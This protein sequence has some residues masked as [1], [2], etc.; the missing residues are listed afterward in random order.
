MDIKV[1][2]LGPKKGGSA[3]DRLGKLKRISLE[4]KTSLTFTL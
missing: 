3:L 4:D 2:I 1:V